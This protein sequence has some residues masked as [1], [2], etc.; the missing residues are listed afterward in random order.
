MIKRDTRLRKEFLLKKHK[1]VDELQRNEKKRKIQ[2]ALDQGKKI[3][4]ELIPE[5]RALHHD[6]EMD[7]RPIEDGVAW[8]DD[9]YANVG[10]YDPK[11]CV[12]TSRDPSSR[13]KQFAK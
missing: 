9:E 3:P 12:T 10:S 7:V 6:L 5:S 2:V 11:V 13:L 4:T 8:F 1:A